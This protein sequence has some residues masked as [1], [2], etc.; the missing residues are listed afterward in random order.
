MR[1]GTILLIGA[2]MTMGVCSARAATIAKSSFGTTRDGK[3]V[4]LYTMTNQHG[5]TVKFMS[6]GGV[7]TEIDVPDRHGRTAD[8]VLGFKTLRDYETK[9]ATVYFGA[10][11]GRYANRIAKGTFALDGKSYQLAVN[12]GANSLHGGAKGFDKQVWDVHADPASGTAASATL[13]YVSRDGEENYPGT[14][15]LHVTYTLTEANELRIRYQATTDKDTVVNFTNHSYFNLAGNG[16]GSVED[17]R[18]S[19]AAARY[20]PID[21]GLIPTGELAPVAGTPLDFRRPTAIG[22]RLR[23]A[24]EQ[25]LRAQGYDFNWVLD[26]GVTSRP[27]PV[28]RAFDPKSG[29]VLECLTTEPGL[30]L[31]TSNFLDGSMTGSAGTIYRQ[32]EAF[33]FETQ[34]FPD[35][36][37][38]PDFP[39]TL[40]KPGQTFDSTTIFRFSTGAS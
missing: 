23:T 21:A 10:L 12:N 17:Q 30:Q 14:L 20:T 22:A 8:V 7:I 34:H 33:T 40:L 25:M 1:Y 9:S 38:H 29:R 37:N 27:R 4:D 2:A 32:T 3:P 26:G 28:A 19:I 18:V 36:P 31:Y 13:T 24:N 35:S 39:T 11:I 5:M 16:S 6:Y 15:T